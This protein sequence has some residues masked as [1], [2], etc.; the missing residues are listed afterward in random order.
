[1]RRLSRQIV[2]PLLELAIAPIGAWVWFAT[3]SQLPTH[4]ALSALTV[5]GLGVTVLLALRFKRPAIAL[6]AV[7][8]LGLWVLA[9]GTLDSGQGRLLERA[10]WILAPWL[11]LVVVAVR[12]P[13]TSRAAL[14]KAAVLVTLGAALLR[15]PWPAGLPAL[16]RWVPLWVTPAVI[17]SLCTGLLLVVYLVRRQETERAAL[18]VLPTLFVSLEAQSVIY[19][20]LG[21]TAATGT[22]L[23]AMMQSS[24]AL[25]FRDELTGLPARRALNETLRSLKG[26][27]ALAMVDIDHFKKFNDRYGHQVGDEALRMVAGRVAEIRGGGKAFRYGGEEFAVVFSRMTANQAAPHLEQIRKEIASVPFF[28]RSSLRSKTKKT[29]KTK[30]ATARRSKGIK[31]TVSIGVAGSARNKQPEQILK[32]ADKQLYR[33]KSHGR[34]QVCAKAASRR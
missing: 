23:I 33:A 31:V 29:K 24:A 8:V 11:T 4:A 14:L 16:F 15:A 25:A 27:Y 13:M 20:L 22:L 28:V 2:V 17:T 7:A 34:N 19:V 10:G 5:G 1:M 30:K 3:N 32:L 21:L 26:N 18:V 9:S 12:G 6:L